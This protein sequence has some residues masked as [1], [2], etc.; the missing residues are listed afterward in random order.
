M[1][2][3][4]VVS[5]ISILVMSTGMT[6]SADPSA[7][8][9]IV[10]SVRD[11]CTPPATAGKYTR[12][13]GQSDRSLTLQTESGARTVSLTT[14][15]WNGVQ[16]VLSSQRLG[17]NENYRNCVQVLAP[18]FL[19]KLDSSD[20]SAADVSTIDELQHRAELYDAAVR[21]R[22]HAARIAPF[23]QNGSCQA[24]A[25]R[26]DQFTSARMDFRSQAA[27]FS[28]TG[29]PSMLPEFG[30]RMDQNFRV[31]DSSITGI[32]SEL[33]QNGCTN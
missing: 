23:S 30:K 22:I 3:A 20:G 7:Y 24:L 11:L 32:L 33:Q 29:N 15:E 27:A 17:D 9:S 21:Q 5:L 12:V 14:E 8:S 16:G 28:R 31:M 1:R 6:S 19:A 25:G 4:I 26:I 10:Q 13:E 18:L 2:I